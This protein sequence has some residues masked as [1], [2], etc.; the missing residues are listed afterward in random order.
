MQALQRGRVKAQRGRCFSRNRL[1][2]SGG[3]A[4]TSRVTQLIEVRFPRA[5]A[6]LCPRLGCF[7]HAAEQPS[8]HW[9]LA[10]P[11]VT[12]GAHNQRTRVHVPHCYGA[13]TTSGGC[14]PSPARS[15]LPWSHPRVARASVR[16]LSHQSRPF[17]CLRQSLKS[18]LLIPQS[19]CYQ[20]LIV[21]CQRRS[22]AASGQEDEEDRGKSR[23]RIANGSEA[24]GKLSTSSPYTIDSCIGG[25]N[26]AL[27]LPRAMGCACCL[28]KLFGARADGHAHNQQ[29]L[30]T[31]ADIHIHKVGRRM[32]DTM[33]GRT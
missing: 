30:A 22:H 13:L 29:R 7:Q 6:A 3:A 21:V 18:L 4:V 20:V 19:S 2:S 11:A 32:G 12:S 8:S 15:T 1:S 25:C 27:L 23:M 26:C 24:S 31:G 28:W 9:Q 17:T 5:G 14:C 10:T 33:G 16:P